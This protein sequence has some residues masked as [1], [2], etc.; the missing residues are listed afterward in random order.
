MNIDDYTVF[1]QVYFYV[2][3]VPP[4][5]MI[6]IIVLKIT[7]ERQPSIDSY[8]DVM[9][10]FTQNSIVIVQSE[11]VSRQTAFLS[12]VLFF[13]D[14]PAVEENCPGYTPEQTA[15]A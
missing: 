5:H 7:N 10:S 4:W 12:S 9:E 11:P 15:R 13:L 14:E 8:R 1:A 2:F 3:T 6:A